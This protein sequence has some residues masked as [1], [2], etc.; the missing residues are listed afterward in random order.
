MQKRRRIW[1]W[2]F[3]APQLIGLLIF[4][5]IP[6]CM[7]FGISF[8]DWDGIASSMKFV[9]LK[10]YINQFTDPDFLKALMNTLVY[11]LIFIPIDMILALALA[12]AVQKI[13]EKHSTDYFIL[14]RW[15]RA[16]YQWGL[17]GH[18]C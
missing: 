14:C 15:L 3:V 9:G 8:H 6:L 13:K 10:N 1:G 5:A 4:A 12:L 7:S 16:P 17:S 2:I 11:S 18:G